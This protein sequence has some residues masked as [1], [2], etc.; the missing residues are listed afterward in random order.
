MVKK[1]ETYRRALIFGTHVLWVDGTRNTK[2]KKES[3]K[4]K[5]DWTQ[6]QHPKTLHKATTEI[7]NLKLI[8]EL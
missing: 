6:K 8:A 5:K 7:K 3:D 2:K 4:K 1:L